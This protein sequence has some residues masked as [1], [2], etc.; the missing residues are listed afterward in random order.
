MAKVSPALFFRQ[1]KQ[2]ISKVTWPSR[3]EATAG[4]VMVLLLSSLAAAF[5]FVVDL[6]FAWVMQF[7]LGFGG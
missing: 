7:I 2:E 6:I 5:F 3:K 4:T 1:V